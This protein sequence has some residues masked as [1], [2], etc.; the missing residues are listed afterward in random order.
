[1]RSV[2]DVI[3][4]I[5]YTAEDG[6]SA[7]AGEITALPTLTSY[8]GYQ[9]LS[10]RQLYSAAWFSFCN[11]TSVTDNNDVTEVNASMAF[12]LVS[13][14]YPANLGNVLLGNAS[15]ETGLVLVLGENA[16]AGGMGLQLNNG[17]TAYW[18]LADN[19]IAIDAPG[20]QVPVPGK[21]NPWTLQ[22]YDIPAGLL[23]TEHTI[24]QT[25]LQD[26]LLVIPFSGT[27]SW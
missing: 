15:G 7:Y 14:M 9:Y 18:P 4:T 12:G 24:N 2:S 11:D 8:H 20:V 21:E 22:L 23:T 3:L 27:L 25:M 13:Q 5:D 19:L 26:I 17:E 16:D 6:G 1:M 10:L